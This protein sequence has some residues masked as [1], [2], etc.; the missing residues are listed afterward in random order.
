MP[1]LS[2]YELGQAFTDLEAALIES[3]GEWTPEVEQAFAALGEL[4]ADK[5]DAY[6]HLIRNTEALAEVL[7]AEKRALEEKRA[8]AANRATRLK[9]K[10][11]EYLTTRGL[12]KVKGTIWTAAIQA[13]GGRPPM[14]VLVEPDQLPAAYTVTVKQVNTGALRAAAE[15]AGGRLEEFGRTLAVIQPRGT[16]LRIR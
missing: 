9:E 1:T 6:A 2:L 5:V 16:H 10:L 12:D 8:V 15:L 11:H 14:E 4:E 7:E 3:G 13:N